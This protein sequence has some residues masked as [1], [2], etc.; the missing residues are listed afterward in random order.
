LPA[1]RLKLRTMQSWNELQRDLLQ[2]GYAAA[3]F[4]SFT[5]REHGT[6]RAALKD[7]TTRYPCPSCDRPCRA[8]FLGPGLTKRALPLFEDAGSL[9]AFGAHEHRPKV[10]VA[11]RR[12]RLSKYGRLVRTLKLDSKES[13][14]NSARLRAWAKTHRRHQFIPE[15]LLDTW[16][17]SLFEKDV[18]AHV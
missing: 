4:V 12:L 8:R 2:G 16:H 7:L 1:S 3:T 14:V 13:L 5:C 9:K 17:L 10:T 15:W 11:T 18:A 6:F